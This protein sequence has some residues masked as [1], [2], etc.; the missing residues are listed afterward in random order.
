MTQQELEQALNEE[1]A[2][3]A[4][5][6]E[7]IRNQNSYITKLEQQRGNAAQASQAGQAPATAALDPT[8]QKYLEEQMRN[9]ITSKAIAQIKSEVTTE[10]YAAV[11]ADFLDFLNRNMN[12]GNT[13]IN[14][15]LDA[16]SLVYG[17]AKRLK[18]HAINN[19]GAKGTTPSS[20]AP[21]V[22]VGTNTSGIDAVNNAIANKPP[23]M[24]GNDTN[25][26]SGPPDTSNSIK[27][28]K[29]AFG[30]LR[31][32]FGQIGANRFS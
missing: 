19:I 6:E 4:R 7:N 14:F 23:M 29:D 24:T 11:E 27:N 31:E 8:L 17:R 18:D 25:A 10:E 21:E 22:N 28:T 26:A 16:F 3:N 9:D 32:K 30:S 12:K 15:V 13:S 2:K 5:L 1:R 20:T